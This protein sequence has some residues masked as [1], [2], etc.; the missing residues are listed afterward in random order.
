MDIKS[1]SDSRWVDVNL[2]GKDKI[3]DLNVP[4]FRIDSSSVL[5]EYIVQKGEDMRMDLVMKSIYD[6]VYLY[7]DIDIILHINHID[8]PLNIREGMV[9]SYPPAEALDNYRYY[10]NGNIVSNKSIKERLGVLN[11]TTRVDEKRK[12]FIDS[13]YSLPPVVLPETR[14]SVVVGDTKIKVGGL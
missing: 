1:L 7:S 4:S 13:N 9:I 14:S 8:N 5:M 6:D 2:D 11:K 10:E 3:L 12:K